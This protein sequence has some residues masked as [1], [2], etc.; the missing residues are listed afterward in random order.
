[1]ALALLPGR[2]ERTESQAGEPQAE[3]AAEPLAAL[4]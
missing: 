3:A 2:P 1:M 4:D